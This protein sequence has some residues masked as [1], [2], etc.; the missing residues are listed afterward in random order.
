MEEMDTI[1]SAAIA[2]LTIVGYA[3][4]DILRKRR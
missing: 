2:L 1:A 3:L 4:F